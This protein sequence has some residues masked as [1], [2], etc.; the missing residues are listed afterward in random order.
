M[1]SQS[2]MKGQLTGRGLVTASVGGQLRLWALD[3]EHQEIVLEGHKDC[4]TSVTVDWLALMALSGS[5]DRTLRLWNLQTMACEQT[6]QGHEGWVWCVSLEWTQRRACSASDDRTVRLWDLK[7]MTCLEV[8]E[9]DV[10]WAMAL[11]VDWG[12]RRALTGG[13]DGTLRIW[14]IGYGEKKSLGSLAGHTAAVRCVAT[15]WRGGQ[16]AA[17]GGGGGQVAVAPRGGRCI[18]GSGDGTLRLWDIAAEKTLTTLEGHSGPVRCVTVDWQH[19]RVLSGS[20]DHSVR[21]WDLT[22]STCLKV[23]ESTGSE[24]RCVGIDWACMAG[25]SGSL[26]GEGNMQ[27]WDLTHG[28]R[29]TTFEHVQGVMALHA[30]G[31]HCSGSD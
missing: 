17:G 3:N 20:E 25:L 10:G 21:L 4:V 26:G 22:E 11:S 6:L 2:I 19:L 29:L 1:Q 7:E 18:S 13:S 30:E 24:I 15:D 5:G 12:A 16:E 27:L 9:M 8:L 14:G 23:L 28:Y 31:F